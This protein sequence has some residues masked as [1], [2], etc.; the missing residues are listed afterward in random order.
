MTN[1]IL[2]LM[3]PAQHNYLEVVGTAVTNMLCTIPALENEAYNIQLAI[4]EACANIIDHAF[5]QQSGATFEVDL[6][7]SSE[8]GRF[9]ACLKDHGQAYEPCSTSSE[10]QP[11]WTVCQTKPNCFKLTAVPEPGFDQ[12]RGR[13]LFLMF[14]LVDQITYHQINDRNEWTLTKKF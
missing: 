5:P 7:V 2:K 3:L 10:T 14:N 6:T 9:T 1:D 11:V 8:C 12:I 13:G 4:H